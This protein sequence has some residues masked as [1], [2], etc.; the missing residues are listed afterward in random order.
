MSRFRGDD[1]DLTASQ[2]ASISRVVNILKR[3]KES[4]IMVEPRG[5]ESPF[6]GVSVKNPKNKEVLRK[7]RFVKNEGAN[8]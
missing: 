5:M 2:E 6:V 1:W 7:L 8:W 4:Y 3:N